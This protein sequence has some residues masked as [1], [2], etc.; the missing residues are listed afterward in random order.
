MSAPVALPAN[1]YIRD[2]PDTWEEHTSFHDY[3]RM[4][5]GFS[6]EEAIAYAKKHLGPAPA[7]VVVHR[8][9]VIEDGDDE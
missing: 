2:V 3:M 9:D 8:V 4:Y 6:R 5:C 1:A 7:K